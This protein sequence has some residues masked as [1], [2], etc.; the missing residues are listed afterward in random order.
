MI[1]Y[2]L[3]FILLFLANDYKASRLSS[4]ITTFYI[5]FVIEDFTDRLFFNI[6]QFELN[7]LLAISISL[8]VA[9]YKYR[10]YDDRD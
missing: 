8:G 6:T 10:N 5:G 3:S 7:D 1:L 2:S 9:I 4:S